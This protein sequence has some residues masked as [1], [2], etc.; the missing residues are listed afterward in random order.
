ML[1]QQHFLTAFFLLNEWNRWKN[2]TETTPKRTIYTKIYGQNKSNAS[3]GI[4]K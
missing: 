4:I 2:R 3:V 1:Y